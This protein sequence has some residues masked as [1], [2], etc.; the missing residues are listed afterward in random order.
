MQVAKNIANDIKYTQFLALNYD[1]FEKTTNYEKAYW[2]LYIHC[3][4]NNLNT[5]YGKSKCSGA[6][7]EEIGYTVFSDFLGKSTNNPDFDEIADDYLEN[8]KKLGI[9]H[10]GIIGTKYSNR[11][12]LTKT[13]NI[14]DIKVYHYTSKNISN[15][16]RLYFNEF[17]EIFHSM[18]KKSPYYI[19]KLSMKKL[20]KSDKCNI[21]E[22]ICVVINGITNL[23]NIPNLS[24]DGQLIYYTGTKANKPKYCHELSSGGTTPIITMP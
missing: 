23:I 11:T 3:V 14:K 22:C 20:D 2:Q 4:A 21:D 16:S 6:I 12:N 19:I 17:G 18:N 15:I 1:I 10:S 9:P 7:N 5:Y 8:D 24:K 13:F